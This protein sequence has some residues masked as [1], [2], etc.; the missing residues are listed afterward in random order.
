MTDEKVVS[1][2]RRV[3]AVGEFLEGAGGIWEIVHFVSLIM[4]S[5]FQQFKYFS[6]VVADIFLIQNNANTVNQNYSSNF[7]NDRDQRF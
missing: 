6:S 2:E 1:Y 5:R 4:I 3:M 7:N